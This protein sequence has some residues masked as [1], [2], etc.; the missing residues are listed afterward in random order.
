MKLTAGN[1]EDGKLVWTPGESVT[2]SGGSNGYRYFLYYPCK[3]GNHEVDA[4]AIDDADCFKSL[5][6]GWQ[7]KEDQS[8]YADYIASDLM[9]ASV[10]LSNNGRSLTFNMT[11]RMALSVIKVPRKIYQFENKDKNNKSAILDRYE[12]G[13]SSFRK[14]TLFRKKIG[15]YAS[16]LA[17]LAFR[18]MNSRRGGTSSPISIENIRSASAAFS[19]VTWRRIRLSGFMVVSQSCSAFI[20]PRPL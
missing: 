13:F 8:K 15:G 17:Y 1:G 18:S 20:S 3:E 16:I 9:T 12:K 10:M 14:K 4:S 6:S 5:I 7:V 2:L 19:I 11:H